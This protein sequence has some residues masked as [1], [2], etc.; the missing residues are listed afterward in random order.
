MNSASGCASFECF[1]EKEQI[2]EINKKIKENILGR[3]DESFAADSV[4]K[5]GDFFHVPCIPL[6]DL[7]SS[8]IYPCQQINASNFGYD[9]YWHFHLDTFNYNVYGIDGEYGWHV[10]VE[11][12]GMQ[13]LS[14]IHI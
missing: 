7:L 8:W 3:E 4:S 12:R 14:L 5:T 1:T 11:P 9:I 10:D 6:M 13:D 2:K